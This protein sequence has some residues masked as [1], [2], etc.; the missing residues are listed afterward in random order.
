M[1]KGRWHKRTNL[2]FGD[3]GEG[4]GEGGDGG[5]DDS[6]EEGAGEEA[7]EGVE[8]QGDGA[9]IP[10]RQHHEVGAQDLQLQHKQIRMASRNLQE[11]EDYGEMRWIEGWLT[12]KKVAAALISGGISWGRTATRE[13]TAASARSRMSRR[14]VAIPLL[15]SGRLG[16]TLLFRIRS[17]MMT[18]ASAG[19]GSPEDPLFMP[20]K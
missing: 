10:Q 7:R 6:E 19:L 20:K 9:L 12:K 4:E 2:R 1:R 15:L 14:G 13:A 11:R 16:L 5:S 8:P 3:G 18:P 17:P